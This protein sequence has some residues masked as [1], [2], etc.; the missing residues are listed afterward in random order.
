MP[1]AK[2]LPSGSWN[3]KVF[4][5]YEYRDGKKVMVKQSFTVD[6]PSP[7]GRRRCEEMAAT[8]AANRKEAPHQVDVRTAIRQYIDA[9]KAVLSPSTVSAYERYL[10]TG[11]FDPIGAIQV[12]KLRQ[13]DVQRW[14]S[15]FAADHSPKYV[16]NIYLLFVPAMKMAGGPEYEVTLPKP[17]PKDVYTPTDDDI[18]RLLE[19]CRKP[20]KEE[21]LAAVLLA[22]FGS[23]RRS[24][25]CALSPEDIQ[26]NVVTVSKAMVMDAGGQWVVKQPKTSNSARRVV[27]PTFVVEL[28]PMQ[29]P[30]IVN[31]SPGALSSRFD[32]AVAA[33]GLP[34]F[35]IHALRHYY[36]S[37]AHALQIADQYTMKMG[38]WRT[39]NVMKRHYRGVMTDV[40]QAAQKKLDAHALQ[41]ISRTAGHETGHDSR[42]AQ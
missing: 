37:A 8:W 27:L 9:K 42:K 40:E 15:G 5:H 17:K 23:M 31:C 13:I 38:G 24:E 34:R 33:V 10:R 2:K 35:S 39:D 22:A 19:H 36:V 21:L 29:G 7:A 26:G 18:V 41:L 32:R 6:D 30:R 12:R 4:S 1:K 28:L 25:I 11:A 14:I 16:K 20:G 3:C